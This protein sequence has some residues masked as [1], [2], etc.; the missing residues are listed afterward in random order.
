[1][2]KIVKVKIDWINLIAGAI[3]GILITCAFNHFASKKYK[4]ELIKFEPKVSM[5]IKELENNI[6]RLR[7]NSTNANAAEIKKL[8]FTIDIPGVLSKKI[9]EKN[10][11]V[12][13]CEIYKDGF[14]GGSKNT[15][16]GPIDINYAE[17]LLIECKSIMPNGSYTVDLVYL[18]ADSIF[19]DSWFS[20]PTN[21]SVPYKFTYLPLDY[22]DYEVLTIYWD[23][24]GRLQNANYCVDLS[25]LKFIQIDNNRAVEF[26]KRLGNPIHIKEYEMSRT[27]CLKN[28]VLTIINE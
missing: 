20:W 11:L 5:S 28:E 22:R 21:A 1:M 23:F 18:P 8:Y 9:N 13:S 24:D 12:E 25:S 27:S 7:I 3:L 17:R 6:L 15:I 16:N 19:K 4:K 26:H 14:I 10:Y 2:L